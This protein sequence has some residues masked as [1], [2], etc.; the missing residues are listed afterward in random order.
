M[1][2]KTITFLENNIREYLHEFQLRKE[3]LMILKMKYNKNKWMR[4]HWKSTKLYHW[5]S[6]VVRHTLEKDICNK[7]L[8]KKF[9][10]WMYVFLRDS[11]KSIIKI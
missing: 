11:Y 8:S 4:L 1:K 2:I 10:H 9:V 5:R 6:E 3:F 7:Q